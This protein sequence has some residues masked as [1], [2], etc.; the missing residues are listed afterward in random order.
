MCMSLHTYMAK[1]GTT[2]SKQHGQRL[3]FF[4]HLHQG[5]SE[6]LLYKTCV[7][8]GGTKGPS[9]SSQFI[10]GEKKKEALLL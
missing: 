7:T 3:M 5:H 6:S 1:H 2:S 9:M 8:V 10:G 4:V